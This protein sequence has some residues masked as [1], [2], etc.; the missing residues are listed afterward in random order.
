[1]I[2]PFEDTVNHV[3][4]SVGVQMSNSIAVHPQIQSFGVYGYLV[5]P[6]RGISG[7]IS[8]SIKITDWKQ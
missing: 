1:M 8:L 3:I 6:L 2:C 5:C 4:N 7:G